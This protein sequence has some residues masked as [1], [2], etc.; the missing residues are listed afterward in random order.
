MPEREEISVAWES[1]PT[2]VGQMHCLRRGLSQLPL[3]LH[4]VA[5]RFLA[6]LRL[7]EEMV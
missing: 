4:S 7:S 3:H 6:S 2:L 1:S 5:P